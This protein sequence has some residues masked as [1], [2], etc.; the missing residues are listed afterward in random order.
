MGAFQGP[1]EWGPLLTAMAT[2]FDSNGK[3]D[4]A[5][6][7]RL[8]HYLVDEQR[9]SGIVVAGTTGESPTLSDDEKFE[10]LRVVLNAVR[11]KAA[12][13]FGAGTYDTAHSVHLTEAATEMGAHGV[14][15]VSPYYNKPN[16]EGLYAHFSEIAKHTDL[17]ILIYNIQ[18]RTS[19]NI[20][21]STLV[22]LAEDVANICAVKEASG[23][24]AQVAEVAARSPEG[25]RVYSGDD[26]LTL[27]VLSVGGIGVVSVVGHIAGKQI[28]EMMETFFATGEGKGGFAAAQLSKKLVPLIQA[29]FCTTNPIPIKYALTLLGFKTDRYRLPMIP[30]TDAQKRKVEEAM[31]AFGLIDKAV[32]AVR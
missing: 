25:F 18:G 13:V 8:A 23:N 2:P 9:N 12:V 20:E 14:M 19:V 4:F 15:L 27:P 29:C 3:V 32:I 30:P 24:V 21:T 5:E 10:L 28:M 17:P 7:E 26:I 6:A 16:Q 1:K 11:S 31:I 22:Q